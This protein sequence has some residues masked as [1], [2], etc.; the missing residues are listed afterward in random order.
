MWQVLYFYQS[1][2]RYY[3]VCACVCPPTLANMCASP[4]GSSRRE[5][6]SGALHPAEARE[7]MY[8]RASHRLSSLSETRASRWT[9]AT[10]WMG[11]LLLLGY[12]FHCPAGLTSAWH[13]PQL[14]ITSSCS[15]RERRGNGDR[16]SET[17]SS[18]CVSTLVC[19]QRLAPSQPLWVKSFF[20]GAELYSF[21]K[22]H[23]HISQHLWLKTVKNHPL[24]ESCWL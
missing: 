14:I 13:H 10:G 16:L 1:G 3:S 23:N 22:F 12:W 17:N 15:Q 4:A 6:M 24:K 8:G 5:N 21:E 19:V 7:M 20:Y 11:S 18:S 2:A 9:G